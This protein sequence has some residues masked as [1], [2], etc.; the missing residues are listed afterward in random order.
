MGT[1]GCF[2]QIYNENWDQKAKEKDLKNLQ[3]GK[4]SSTCKLMT[5]KRLVAKE[6]SST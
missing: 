1:A 6:V 3:F 2:N 5:K 4:K